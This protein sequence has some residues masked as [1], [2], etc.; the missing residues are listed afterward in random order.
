MPT[1][2]SLSDFTVMISDMSGANYVP[3]LV[4]RDVGRRGEPPQVNLRTLDNLEYDDV[5][6]LRNWLNDWLGHYHD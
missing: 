6:R 1:K 3:A 4:A 2:T 5:L